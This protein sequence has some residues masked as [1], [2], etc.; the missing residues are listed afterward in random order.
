[1]GGNDGEYR[2]FEVVDA[3]KKQIDTFLQIEHFGFHFLHF[4]QFK[5]RIFVQRIYIID[6]VV[7]KL[8]ELIAILRCVVVKLDNQIV[9]LDLCVVIDEQIHS[10]FAF[11]NQIKPFFATRHAMSY[12]IH[13][14]LLLACEV[15][16][17]ENKLWIACFFCSTQCL[18]FEMEFIASLRGILRSLRDRRLLNC[19][20]ILAE[21]AKWP[22]RVGCRRC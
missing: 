12:R 20:S 16:H 8:I 21:A 3:W 11:A 4:V 15:N 10:S 14:L 17:C 19:R 18:Q 13:P 22:D 6:R 5:H 1:M 2:D 7:E 9:K